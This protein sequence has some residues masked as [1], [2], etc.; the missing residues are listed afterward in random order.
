MLR[1]LPLRHHLVDEAPADPLDR[2]QAEP[3]PS[4]TTV[5]SGPDSFTSGGSRGIPISRH[6]PIYSATFPETSSTLVSSAAIYSRG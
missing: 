4:A 2:H 1:P 6:S 5:K 3:N